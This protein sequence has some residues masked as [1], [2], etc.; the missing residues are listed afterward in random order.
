MKLGNFFEP[1]VK[2]LDLDLLVRCLGKVKN[3]LDGEK[4]HGRK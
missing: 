2:K 1:K 3:I 4:E